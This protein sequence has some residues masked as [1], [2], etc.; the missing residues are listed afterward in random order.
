[1]MELK[2]KPCLKSEDYTTEMSHESMPENCKW[3][4]FLDSREYLGDSDD[5]YVLKHF[6][7]V[8]EDDELALKITNET[9]G[10]RNGDG[11]FYEQ[12]EGEMNWTC[13]TDEDAYTLESIF[14]KSLDSHLH[15]PPLMV[16]ERLKV[17]TRATDPLLKEMAEYL[18]DLLTKVAWYGY[19][20][21]LE[22]EF[23]EGK[24]IMQKYHEQ[25]GE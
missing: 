22:T 7:L 24:V 5:D 11:G 19:D 2:L 14:I 6:H 1:M 17:Q 13:L 9:M 15:M 25:E 8:R 3:I 16:G 21:Q 4:G 12:P 10:A 18:H 23:E 20:F